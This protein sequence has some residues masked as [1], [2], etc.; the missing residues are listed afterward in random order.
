M[1]ISNAIALTA[2]L[3]CGVPLISAYG[4]KGAA[5]ALVV[6]ELTLAVS[7]ESSLSS[8]R[9]ESRLKLS[10]VLRAVAATLLAGVAASVVGLPSVAAAVLGSALY[11]VA[12][13]ALGIIPPEI[14]EG[15]FRRHPAA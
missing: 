14:R 13:L 9:P 11:V 2:V 12:L 3:A 1:L 8:I 10:F 4:A 15:I 7:Y 6:A 5:I